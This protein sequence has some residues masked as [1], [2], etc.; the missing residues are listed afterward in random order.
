MVLVLVSSAA[1]G[2]ERNE[3]H[4]HL[5][6]IDIFSCEAHG[7]IRGHF[8]DDAQ[9]GLAGRRADGND[10]GP[11]CSKLTYERKRNVVDAACHDDFVEKGTR[12]SR[13]GHIPGITRRTMP[14]ANA[15]AWKMSPNCMGTGKGKTWLV[16]SLRSAPAWSGFAR[17]RGIAVHN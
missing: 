13:P 17:R 3:S 1:Q 12:S 16:A 10:Y 7:S 8:L 2:R 11:V 14:A 15:P 5:P 9:K 6:M 4:F